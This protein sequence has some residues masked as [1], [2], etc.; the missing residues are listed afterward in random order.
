MV[1]CC[2]LASIVQQC[3]LTCC[4]PP[5]IANEGVVEI[6]IYHEQLLHKAFIHQLW[7]QFNHPTLHLLTHREQL[8]LEQTDRE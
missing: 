5:L 6:I 1:N 7:D 2:N 4:S 8:L 3:N